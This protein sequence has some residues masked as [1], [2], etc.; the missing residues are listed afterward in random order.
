MNKNKTILAAALSLSVVS[1]SSAGTIY[2]T[3]STAMRGVVYNTMIAPGA[4]FTAA[5]TTTLFEGGGSSA[6]YMAFSGTLVGGTGTTIIQCHWSGSEGGIKDVALGTT[7]TFMDPTL[8]DGTDHGT[9]SPSLT[10][11]HAADLAMADNA[12]S[13]SRT[14]T[15]ALTTFKEVGVITFA[16]VRNPGLWTGS[17]LTDSMIRQALKGFCK[18][19]VF[20]GNAGDTADFVYVSGRDN[21]SGTRVNAFGNSGFGIFTL[22]KQIEMD[23]SGNMQDLSGAGD[24]AGDYGFSSGGTL[25]GTMGAVTTNK[26]DLFN[27]GATGYSVI[28][29]LSRGDANTAIGKGAVELTYNGIAESAAAIK[30]GTYTF[31]GNEYIYQAN[32]AGTEA[33]SAYA[34]LS[35]SATGINNYCDGVKAIKLTDMHCTRTGPTTDPSHP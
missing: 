34:R 18:R 33:Q 1:L 23:S 6:N 24:Y 14:K 20:S 10:T 28:A 13:F 7:E 32:G 3:G 11:S 35:N 31:W 21:Q 22:P 9:N 27:V 30:E 2:M 17:N 16:W 15:P 26:S 8:M 19:A 5:P 12:Q 4:V 25:A 29:Y